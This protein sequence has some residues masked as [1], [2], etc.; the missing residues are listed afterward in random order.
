VQLYAALAA[1]A[2][3]YVQRL[4]ARTCRAGAH[5]APE[6]I[7]RDEQARIPDETQRPSLAEQEPQTRNICTAPIYTS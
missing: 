7:C 4:V 5:A 1:C 2:A 6:C 3:A